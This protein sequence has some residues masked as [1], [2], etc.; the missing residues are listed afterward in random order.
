M[1]TP[2]MPANAKPLTS[3][4]HCAETSSQRSPICSQMPGAEMP[5]CGSLA[6]SGLPDS[7][8]SPETTHEF[9]PTP[10]PSPMRCG[11]A[12]SAAA[13]DAIAACRSALSRS[14]SA[15]VADACCA[16]VAGRSA[17]VRIGRL[18]SCG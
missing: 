4:G 8:R 9:E 3:Y 15:V 7:V 14:S 18:R 2:G 17:A 6:S 12:S 1:T 10:S 16:A 11:T 13:A 5:R